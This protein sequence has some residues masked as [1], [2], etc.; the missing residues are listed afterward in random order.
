MMERRKRGRRRRS[1]NLIYPMV[2]C[3]DH[4]STVCGPKIIKAFLNKMKAN[5]KENFLGILKAPNYFKAW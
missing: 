3:R 1:P 4:D 2:S 5:L